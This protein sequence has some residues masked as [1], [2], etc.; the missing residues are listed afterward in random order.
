MDN[1]DKY[2]SKLIEYRRSFHKYPEPGWCEFRTTYIIYKKLIEL[3]Y[4]VKYGRDIIE[5]KSR[6]GV[7]D[8]A[9]LKH[10]AKLAS[11]NG[12]D[13]GFLNEIKDGYTGIVAELDI[14]K[15]PTMS[16]RFDIDC[17]TINETED[18]NHRPRQLGFAS[19]NDG[20]AHSCGH[21]GHI[22][23][24]LT[25]AE[26]IANNKHLLNGKIIL[27]F[28][29]AEEGVRGA[30]AIVDKGVLPKIDYMFGGHIGL[31]TESIGSFSAGGTGF[32]ASK[33]FDVV[34]KGKA[35]HA[36]N[37][38]EKGINALLAA[39][40]II[41]GFYNIPR[42]SQ[43]LTMIN[44][45]VI[46]AGSFRSAIPENAEIQAE[47]RGENNELSSYMYEKA[48][49]I[50]YNISKAYGCQYKILEAG[51]SLSEDCSH[52][53]VD[54]VYSI[55]E[56]LGIY[57][58]IYKTRQIKG[59]EDFTYFMKHVKDNGGQAT[60]MLWG[61][62]IKDSFHSSH[63]DFSEESMVKALKVLCELLKNISTGG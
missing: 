10:F 8:D 28:Q 24:G 16:F 58:D 13:S 31:S 50:V 40:S 19:A 35:S 32:L 41:S 18:E 6:H 46:N 45:G 33:K 26:I 55:A 2:Y 59:S 29:P 30:K 23:I 42:H 56:K 60:Y 47:V 43:G 36:A 44:V 9:T 37:S 63:F 20:Y 54:K 15:G 5:E 12:V 61:A 3:G 38:P 57:H 53:L 1:I 52:E 51:S 48:A 17:V 27:I 49:D 39:N 11:E 34:L 21:D 7:P 22:S 14:S 62:D 25:F 4:D